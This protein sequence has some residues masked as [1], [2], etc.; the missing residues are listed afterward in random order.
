M[1]GNKSNVGKSPETSQPSVMTDFNCDL[2]S[3]TLAPKYYGINI[4][5]E[6]KVISLSQNDI[7]SN[8]CHV[9]LKKL[10][11]NDLEEINVTL[12]TKQADSSSTTSSRDEKQV[13]K[14]SLH[15]HKCPSTARIRAQRL[16]NAQNTKIRRKEI[17][18]VPHKMPEVPSRQEPAATNIYDSSDDTIIYTPPRLSPSAQP[19]NRKPKA[20]FVIRT[21]G[22]KHYR[23]TENVVKANA[24]NLNIQML[25]MQ[26]SLPTS[27]NIH[28]K[29]KHEGLDCLEC[30]QEFSNPMSV[31]KHSYYHKACVHHCAYCEKTF[32]FPSQKTF[33]ER[34]HT[35]TTWHSCPQ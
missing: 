5:G 26:A 25:P 12:H 3:Q 13:K 17:T 7:L 32:P 34:I 8:K 29:D 24:Q 10:S 35:N 33:H 2:V 4:P 21:V 23:D 14:I 15:P 9:S 18:P 20:K 28:F 22:I 31:K 1:C 16:I 27:L 19:I 6:D 30:G 11:D